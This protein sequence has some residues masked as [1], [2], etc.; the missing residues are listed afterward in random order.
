MVPILAYFPIRTLILHSEHLKSP[1]IKLSIW[2]YQCLSQRTLTDWMI[3]LYLL[4]TDL[5]FIWSSN[6]SVNNR[7]ISQP[8]SFSLDDIEVIK[9]QKVRSTLAQK[10]SNFNGILNKHV[11]KRISL[12][13]SSPRKFERLIQKHGSA[14]VE[15]LNVEHSKFITDFFNTFVDFKWRFIILL[16]TITFIGSWSFFSMLWFFLSVFYNTYFSLECITGLDINASFYEYYLFSIETQQ[17]IGYGTRAI[18]SNCGLAG[19]ILMLQCG[20]N[21]FLECFLGK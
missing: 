16:F 12:S 17:T 13:N 8:L 7:V 18:T 3:N 5:Y 20:C 21:I 15:R 19:V 9:H 1:D 11:M 6:N 2:I 10:L 4:L 14:N